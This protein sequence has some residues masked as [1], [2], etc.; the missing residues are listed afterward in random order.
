MGLRE[1]RPL[2]WLFVL[3]GMLVAG[4][5]EP[6]RQGPSATALQRRN[7]DPRARTLLW[8]V[9]QAQQRQDYNRTLALI[10]SAAHYAPDFADIFFLRGRVLTR[11]YRFDQAQ[12]A[13]ERVLELD[14][15]YRS[16]SY[17][18]G[19]NAF[20]LGRNR[21]AIEHY[22]RERAAFK[23]GAEAIAREGSEADRAALASVLLQIGRVYARLGVAD[24][25]RQAYQEALVIEEDNAQAWGWLAELSEDEGDLDLALSEARRA[26]ALMPENIEYRYLVGALS[27]RTG[28]FEE[29]VG[30]LEAVVR[31]QAWHVGAHYNLG[32]C[33]L[34]LGREAEAQQYLDATD[35][36]QQLD[37]DIVLA[38]FALHRNPEDPAYW[39]RLVAL[40]RQAGRMDE[41]REAFNIVRQLRP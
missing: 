14:P 8:D 21:E 11:L 2:V 28:A 39:T 10:D 35:A 27:F 31:Q 3:A 4:C 40:Y 37:S 7:L 23:G 20:L 19:N 29:A 41:A 36:L 5:G 15:T 6:D 30:H 34:A 32:R 16:A 33:L 1:T 18:M 13:F 38:K 17:N 24:S 25:A 12:A 26:F 22:Q 9:Q